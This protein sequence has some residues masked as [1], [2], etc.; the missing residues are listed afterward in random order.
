MENRESRESCEMCERRE[1]STKPRNTVKRYEKPW[2]SVGIRES[3]ESCEIILCER[4]ESSDKPRNV[5]TH[6][7]KPMES[8]RS[9]E[10]CDNAQYHLKTNGIVKSRE[11]VKISKPQ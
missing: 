5:V 4:R 11:S 9:C 7:G 3:S 8:A 2:E 10:S 6:S 1:S